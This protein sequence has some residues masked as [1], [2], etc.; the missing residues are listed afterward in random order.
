A[1]TALGVECVPPTHSCSSPL[2]QRRMVL[3]PFGCTPLDVPRAASF[4]IHWQ[5]IVWCSIH[6]LLQRGRQMAGLSGIAMYNIH[7]DETNTT[8][9]GRRYCENPF[10]NEPA[11]RPNGIGT[12]SRMHPRKIRRKRKDR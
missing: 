2:H 1:R 4:S 7:R 10:D 3:P 5:T 9:S 12:C 11:K 8:L 6:P